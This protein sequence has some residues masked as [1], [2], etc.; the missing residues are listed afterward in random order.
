MIFA[1][2][3]PRRGPYPYPPY[4]API[5]HRVASWFGTNDVGS[6]DLPW[7]M[8]WDGDRR[9]IWLP[10]TVEEFYELH[11]F[12]APKGVSFLMLTPYLLNQPPQ[13]EVLKGQYRGWAWIMTR[14]L[15]QNFPLKA[16]RPL[17]PDGE[18]ILLADRVRWPQEIPASQPAESIETNAP[19]AE[20]NRLASGRIP[21][22]CDSNQCASIDDRQQIGLAQA[23]TR[24]QV[25]TC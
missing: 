5:T 11:D 18:Q 21:A 20:T 24:I 16:G 9:T 15:P 4:F 2:L 17:W 1:L 23:R 7:A 3:P 12:V 25:T 13:S 8:A 14:Q 22:S 6:S 10:S 19:P